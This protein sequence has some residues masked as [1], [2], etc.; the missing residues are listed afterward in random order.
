MK[1][2]NEL[3]QDKENFVLLEHEEGV[4]YIFKDQKTLKKFKVTPVNN[5]KVLYEWM[6]TDG[7]N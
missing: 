2:I 3:L 1:I 4:Y 5:D 6:T 7:T